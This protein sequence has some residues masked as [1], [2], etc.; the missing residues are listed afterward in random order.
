MN[1]QHKELEQVL[2]ALANR[3]RLAILQIIRGRRRIHVGG[4]AQ[5]LK[6]SFRAVSQHLALLAKAGIVEHEQVGLYMH[7]SLAPD[8]PSVAQKI[9]AQ[10]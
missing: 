10:L 5:V 4:I 1:T 3:R 6:L 7:Y 8:M 9:I 2:K